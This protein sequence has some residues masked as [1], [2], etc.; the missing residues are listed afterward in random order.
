MLKRQQGEGWG[1]KVI[2]RLAADLKAAFPEMKGFSA[3]NIKYMRALAEAWPDSEFVQ[4]VLAQ[5]PWYHNITLLDKVK[6]RDERAWYINQT[7]HHGWSRN[8]LVHQIESELYQRQSQAITNFDQTLMPPQSDLARQIL[9]DPYNFDF[10]SLGDAAHERELERSLLHHLQDFL[11]DL[12]KGFAFVG[13]QY[14]LE[15]GG[16]DF[17][18]DLLFYHLKLRSYVV[19]ELKVGEFKPEY[20]GKMN[21]YLSA[22]DAQLKHT[23]DQPSIGLILCKQKNRLIA[24][25]ALRDSGKPIGIS[26]YQLTQV[27]PSSIAGE[28]PTIEELESELSD[29]DQHEK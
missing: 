26:E 12:G 2:D 22:V 25:Y 16:E 11:L 21:F 6:D 28:L 13:S 9:K 14:H 17:Y 15:V 19:I 3:R 8:V 27:L 4:E 5:I 10:L 7:I 1:T 18:I 20:A 24:E 29:D 23:D